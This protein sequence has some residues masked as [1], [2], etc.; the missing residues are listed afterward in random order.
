MNNK[1]VN[2]LTTFKHFPQF[3][4]PLTNSFSS[5]IKPRQTNTTSNNKSDIYKSSSSSKVSGNCTNYRSLKIECVIQQN[6]LKHYDQWIQLLL[7]IIGDK[8][9]D[10]STHVD[11]GTPIQKGLES[12]VK[13]QRETMIINENILIQKEKNLLLKSKLEEKQNILKELINESKLED[14]SHITQEK[15][16]LL[17]NIQSIANELD[18]QSEKYKNINNIITNKHKD[19]YKQY[20]TANAELIQLKLTNKQY[21]DIIKLNRNKKQSN[22]NSIDEYITN[23][24]NN[25]NNSNNAEQ[26]SSFSYKTNSHSDC[27]NSNNLL[28]MTCGN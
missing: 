28:F 7:S 24:N 21:K 14:I 15:N 16:V 11:I 5:P 12:I 25:S 22:N 27:M 19:E 8:P 10:S 2:N 17:T 3:N 13:I 18:E 1:N 4:K 20:C 9:I 23:N 6:L 26:F